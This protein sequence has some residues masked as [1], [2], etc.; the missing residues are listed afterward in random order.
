MQ[1]LRSKKSGTFLMVHRVDLSLFPSATY[2]TSSELEE[3]K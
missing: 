1:E 3:N 2:P